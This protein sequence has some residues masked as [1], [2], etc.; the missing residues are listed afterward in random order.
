[1]RAAAFATVI[2]LAL[3]APAGNA[4][5]PPAWPGGLV[6]VV[7]PYG[8]G[9]AAD[10]MTR[11]FTTQLARQISQPVIVENRPGANANIA[12]D[13]VAKAAPNGLTLLVSGPF[14]AANP[15]IDKNIQWKPADF[16]PVARFA[17]VS[18]ALIVPG[19]FK[20][21]T[22]KDFV[23]SVR[24]APGQ[25]F[26]DGGPGSA[27]ALI[28]SMLAQAARLDLRPVMYKSAPAIINDVAGGRIV[29]S[30]LSLGVVMGPHKSGH[31]K[32]LAITGK[33]RSPLLPQVPTLVESGYADIE[34]DSWYGLHAPAGTPAGVIRQIAQ[35]TQAATASGEVQE[36]L[37]GAAAEAAYLDGAGFAAFVEE[38]RRRWVR[39]APLMEPVR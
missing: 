15:V 39:F 1:M 31:V 30:A 19:S 20:G 22:V 12:P 23:E 36:R 14:F 33:K 11:I 34:V 32:V 13:Q 24:A 37:L 16:T 8:A 27:Q 18:N 38:E 21:E 5:E 28:V 7:V 26:G 29:V 9:G 10:V 4:A 2:L 3:G 6:R 35:A 25:M 17:V